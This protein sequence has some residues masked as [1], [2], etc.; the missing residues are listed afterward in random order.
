MF[1][2]PTTETKQ[3]NDASRAA[4]KPEAARE[5]S[6]FSPGMVSPAWSGASAADGPPRG[7]NGGIGRQ[8]A[9]LHS[10][11]GNQAIL[12]TLSHAP[13]VIQTKL[14][15]NKPGDEYE[16]EA[17]RVADQVMRMTAPPPQHAQHL[18]PRVLGTPAL[19]PSIHRKCSSCEEEEKVQRKCAECEQEEKQTGLQLKEAGAGPHSAPPSVHAVLNSPGRPLDP[20]TRAFMEPRF[21]VDFTGV[22]VHDDAQAAESAKNVNA[23]AYTHGRNI[24]FNAGQYAPVSDRG[25][26]L[27]AHELAHVVQ[28]SGTGQTLAAEAGLITRF[29][30]PLIMRN[31]GPCEDKCKSSFE[32]C[33][34]SGKDGSQCEAE[35]S[36]CLRGCP[37]PESEQPAEPPKQD[38]PAAPA[39]APAAKQAVAGTD[40]KGQD[41]VVYEKEI[42]VAG[43]RTWRNINPGNFDKA[44]DHPRNIGNDSN[45]KAGQKR[46]F[47]IFPDTA[48]GMQELI[49]SIKAHGTS[50]IGS[51]ITVHAPPSENDTKK[52]IREVVGYMNNADAIGECKVTR[53]AKPVSDATMIGSMSDSEQVSL[54]M[55]MAREEGFCD[56]TQKKATYTCDSKS[57]PDE[58]KG[59]L[60]C[61]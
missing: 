42:R 27:L 10:I 14:A 13:S 51:F 1:H 4:A 9:G 32:A 56:V 5:L 37:P 59:K 49:D 33:T 57:V 34:K 61:P 24:V 35:L 26:H 17:D 19:A 7:N 20:A 44:A 39:A 50:T 23:L 36:V 11:Y 25:R 3:Q 45:T 30:S 6:P 22:R 55:A 12:R 38:A 58:Y 54:A 29:A 28:Q 2:A 18:N 31:P 8:L 16:Q 48:T 47:L 41:F 52:Y 60:T 21:G 40:S 46:S 43:T 15:V 53:P